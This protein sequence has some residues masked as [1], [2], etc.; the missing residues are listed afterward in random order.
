MP[1]VPTV[2]PISV[3]L[4]WRDAETARWLEWFRSHPQEALFTPAGEGRLATVHGVIV[5]VFAVELRYAQRLVDQPVSDWSEI[6]PHTLDDTFAVGDLARVLIDGYLETADEAS[7]DTALSFKTLSA[8]MM[9]ATKRK[10][11]FSLVP[12][13]MRHWAQIAMLL[14]QAGHRDQ[15][16]HDLLASSVMA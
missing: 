1:N 5:H 2:L 3:M 6:D 7:L 13:G 12:H 9:T 11:L 14:R 15:W 4:A 16:A 10:I 8:G